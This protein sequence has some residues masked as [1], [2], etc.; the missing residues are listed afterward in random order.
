MRNDV[1]HTWDRL[2]PR[3]FRPS[4]GSSWARPRAAAAITAISTA[5]AVAGLHLHDT[6]EGTEWTP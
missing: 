3:A 1:P 5:I 6:L 2:L 4:R